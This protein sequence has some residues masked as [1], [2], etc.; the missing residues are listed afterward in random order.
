MLVLSRKPKE[1]IL[2]D[3]KVVVTVLRIQGDLVKIGIQAPV[4]VRVRRGGLRETV[5]DPGVASRAV[6]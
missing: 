4:E 1:S 2:I 6:G 5:G 3:G